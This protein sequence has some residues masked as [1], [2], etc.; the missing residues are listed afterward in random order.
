MCVLEVGSQST[1]SPH[2]MPPNGHCPTTGL[3]R[4]LDNKTK[5][6]VGAANGVTGEI[7]RLGSCIM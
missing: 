3:H 5:Y 6:G 1:G 4:A 2:L 7:M